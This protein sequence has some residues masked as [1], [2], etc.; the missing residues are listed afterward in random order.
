MESIRLIRRIRSLT[1][2]EKSIEAVL[3]ILRVLRGELL[4]RPAAIYVPVRMTPIANPS[5]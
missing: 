3:G 5:R 4:L 1:S 2:S